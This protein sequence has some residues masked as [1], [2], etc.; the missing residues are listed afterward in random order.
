MTAPVLSAQIQGQGV[1]SA[2][3]LNTYA[4]WC[5]STAQLR[6]FIGLPSMLVFLEGIDVP[7]DGGQ[8]FFLWLATVSQSDDNQNY[9]IPNGSNGGGWVRF[10]VVATIVADLP[11]ASSFNK[12]NRA[13]VT[14][15]AASPVLGSAATGGGSL[16]LPVYSDGSTWRNG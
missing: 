10:G 11:A 1:V 13:F 5:T 6:A 9:I 16:Y 3:N 4:Q 7:D 8:G 14:D 15:S 2:D 12:G